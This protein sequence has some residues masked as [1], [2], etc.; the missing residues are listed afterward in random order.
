MLNFI[1]DNEW[2]SEA[3]SAGSSSCVLLSRFFL[4]H[5]NAFANKDAVFLPIFDPQNVTTL[6]HPL[7][8]ADFSPPDCC[9]L[10]T[11]KLMLKAGKFVNISETKAQ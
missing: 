5:H 2:P 3:N 10:P 11:L 7:C 4:L 8:S 6:Y 1:K 9:L